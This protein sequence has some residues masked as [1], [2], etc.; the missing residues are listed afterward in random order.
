M[1]KHNFMETEHITTL[2]I[3]FSI[4]AVIGM[5]VN[6]L[7]N[8]VD[9]IYIGNMKDVGHYPMAGVGLTFPTVIFT[10]A[11]ALLIGVGAS[12]NISLKLGEKNINDAEH[13]LG[14]SVFASLIVSIVM[15]IAYLFF[16][17]KILIGLGGEGKTLFYAKEYFFTLSFGIPAVIVG[18]TLNSA[19]RSDGSP[20]VAMGTLLI[21]AI[22]NIALDPI[23]IFALDMGV[24]GAA[25]ATI[26]SQ[27]LSLIWTIY[28][29][30]YGSSR[31]KLRL[32]NISYN[33]DKIY[34]I[35][36]LGSSAF[37][38]QIGFALVT[39][40]L[41]E[42]LYKYGG[43]VSVAAMA[44]IQSL[45]SFLIMPI[46]GINQ[47]V[48][49]IIGYNYGARLY[50]RVKE[51]L[52][53][54]IIGA[55][56]IC[57]IGFIL[58]MVFASTM[59]KIFTRDEKLISLAIY[60]L[61]IYSIMLPIVGAQIVSS[62]YFQAVGK[63]K[64]SF[65]ISLSRQILVLIPCLFIL[66]YMFGLNGIFFAAPLSDLIASI[67]TFIL[68]RKEIEHLNKKRLSIETINGDEKI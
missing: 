32:K 8:I 39:Y 19:I 54:G 61:R 2:L 52:F 68:I 17:N 37:A 26:I 36:A 14:V 29:F 25:V 27:Y 34:R 45:N 64:M 48:Q 46:F 28:Y 35:F 22:T 65:L 24:R 38:I 6:A 10:F 41:N 47:G 44:I 30:T 60:G 9:R 21:G 5:V 4:P 50:G 33:F 62:V 49:P 53:K 31:I 23:F 16:M 51:A 18:N 56:I 20:K 59:I 40:F 11:F 66:S 55:T 58:S 12:A 67:I 57:V 42:R 7:Y 1:N 3:K 43:D 15:A 63:P 13:Y